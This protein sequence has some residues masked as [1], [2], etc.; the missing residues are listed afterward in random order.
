M[1]HLLSIIGSGRFS[2]VVNAAEEMRIAPEIVRVLIE[3]LTR[4]GYLRKAESSIGQKCGCGSSCRRC[5]VSC[6][7]GSRDIPIW[8]LTTSGK[9]YIE[10]E[11]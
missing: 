3:D 7:S 9:K 2:S 8:E 1:E 6:G 5:P 11:P 10:L 4:M